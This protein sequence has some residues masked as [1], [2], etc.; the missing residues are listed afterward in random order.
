MK[1][2]AIPLAILA[3]ALLLAGA[4]VWDSVRY[5]A[6]ARGRVD[7]ADK[8]LKKHE[9]R[10]VRLVAE[11]PKLT[12]EVQSALQLYRAAANRQARFDAYDRVT[13][14]FRKTMADKVD[15]TNPLERKFMDDIAGAINRRDVAAKTFDNESTN[16]YTFLDGFRG[17]IANMFSSDVRDSRQKSASA[18]DSRQ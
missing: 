1:K 15:A 10:L 13:D 11:S 18:A 17:R 8:E 16:Y 9:A 6:D 2:S 4:F 14:S 7:L 12:T 5:A 3:M